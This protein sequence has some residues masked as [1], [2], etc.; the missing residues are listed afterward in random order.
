MGISL[1]NALLSAFFGALG[2]YFNKQ[3]TFSTSSPVWHF[4]E[5]KGYPKLIWAWD[6]GCLILMLWANTVSVKYKMMSYKY[7]GA[8]LGTT[9]IFILGYLFSSGF[10]YLNNQTIMPW[11][12]ISGAL[13]IIVGVILI[14]WQ[15]EEANIQKKT[16]SFYEV[17][18]HAHED[19]KEEGL[20][21]RNREPTEAMS[22]SNDMDPLYSPVPVSPMTL[23]HAPKIKPKKALRRGKTPSRLVP[24]SIGAVDM[25]QVRKGFL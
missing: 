7:D 23:I 17:L 10:D 13:L 25:I 20:I 15:E 21:D 1:K 4:L 11:S 18:P 2:P 16:Q 12:R 6:I 22:P 14:S 24:N 8:F 9:L 3:I 5:E 19:E